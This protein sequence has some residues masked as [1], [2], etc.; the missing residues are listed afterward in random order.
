MTSGLDN[1][2][3]LGSVMGF[4]AVYAGCEGWFSATTEG[5][6]DDE[7]PLVSYP[8][9]ISDG[10]CVPGNGV[11]WVSIP[12]GTT[13]PPCWMASHRASAPFPLFALFP[14]DLTLPPASTVYGIK[15]VPFDGVLCRIIPSE[16]TS[17]Y[18][19]RS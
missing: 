14:V 11:G 18:L 7:E 8:T 5:C 15:K 2:S 17:C 10:D 13:P 16:G 4:N 6:E 1:E 3:A 12:G 9:K 19:R